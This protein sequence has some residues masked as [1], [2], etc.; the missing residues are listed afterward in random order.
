VGY[1]QRGRA[2]RTTIKILCPESTRLTKLEE[3]FEAPETIMTEAESKVRAEVLKIFAVS[4][5]NREAE[6]NY[7][8]LLAGRHCCGEGGRCCR[9]GRRSCGE[10]RREG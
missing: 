3:K 8:I 1:F 10:D 4:H 6:S 7:C 5:D 9:E 2:H